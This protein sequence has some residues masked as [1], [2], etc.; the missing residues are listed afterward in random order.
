MSEL[1]GVR[2]SP[3]ALKIETMAAS[4]I[5]VIGITSHTMPKAGQPSWNRGPALEVV[6]GDESLLNEMVQLFMVESP[7]LLSQIEEAALHK[8]LKML[9][10][11]VHS[12]RGE[13]RYLVV[14]EAS[15]IAEK[16]EAAARTGD[17]EAAADLM[18]ALRTQLRVLWSMLTPEA[19]LSESV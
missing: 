15:R 1:D 12:L 9:E 14:P 18:A 19:G 8:D 5:P 7:M 4:Q 17:M 10:L 6:G 2:V 13:L 3:E 11:A 16:L